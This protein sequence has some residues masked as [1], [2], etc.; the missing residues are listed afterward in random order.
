[1]T[2]ERI[3]GGEIHR[4]RHTVGT[5][6]LNN[7]W[8]QAEVQEFF[9]HATP[10]MTSHYAKISHSTLTAAASAGVKVQ[11]S[12]LAGFSALVK[13]AAVNPLDLAG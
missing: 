4:Y 12:D 5:A 9:G 6:L 8:T 10:T 7:D 1:M 13:R 11:R 3:T 2:G